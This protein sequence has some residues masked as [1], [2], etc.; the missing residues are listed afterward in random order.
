LRG[1]RSSSQ[2]PAG[3]GNRHRRSSSSPCLPPA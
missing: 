1:S 2:H 3:E